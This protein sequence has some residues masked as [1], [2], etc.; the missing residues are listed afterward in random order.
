MQ[1][2]CASICSVIQRE[3]KQQRLRERQMLQLLLI[4]LLSRSCKSGTNMHTR[5]S[6]RYYAIY[7]SCK[8]RII[9]SLYSLHVKCSKLIV[10]E[11]HFGIIL[12]SMCL[13]IFFF[14]KTSNSVKFENLIHVNEL[15][16]SQ[17]VM[18]HIHNW[19]L[20]YMSL[21][22]PSRTGFYHLTS[23]LRH[24]IV[25]TKILVAWSSHVLVS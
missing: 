1:E 18:S 4:W 8:I 11:V 23:S 14:H 7:W 3:Q 22:Q 9:L 16:T 19:Y 25:V 17:S 13:F 5:Y 20:S 12:T 15:L 6:V 10:F 21:P 2:L 24:P